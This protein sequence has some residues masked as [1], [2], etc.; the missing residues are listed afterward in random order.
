MSRGLLHLLSQA[1]SDLAQI[2]LQ[3]LNKAFFGSVITIGTDHEASVAFFAERFVP[4]N[5]LLTTV[6]LPINKI[7]MRSIIHFL[8]FRTRLLTFYI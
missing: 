1:S 5:W 8:E 3:A 2:R 6:E 7:D 4:R